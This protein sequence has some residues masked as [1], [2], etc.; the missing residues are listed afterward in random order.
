MG[1]PGLEAFLSSGHTVA[2]ELVTLIRAAGR[3]L[4]AFDHALDFGCGCGRVMR[5]MRANT[6]GLR[7]S[8]TDLDADA[9]AWLRASMPGTFTTNGPCPPVDFADDTFDLV[10]AVSVFTHLDEGAQMSWLAEIARVLAPGGLG[11]LT[12]HGPD[13]WKTFL[14]GRRPGIDADELRRLRQLPPVEDAGF[15]FSSYSA[16]QARALRERKD[17]PYGLAAHTPA[18]IR[19]RW[20]QVFDIVD[21]VPAAVNWGQDAVLVTPRS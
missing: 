2:E 11:V 18:Y 10:Y 17:E 21:I 16:G 5:F 4:E 20:A 12:V 3:D 19:A 1:E 14:A 6:P 8:G 9:I 13:L 7:I 15:V